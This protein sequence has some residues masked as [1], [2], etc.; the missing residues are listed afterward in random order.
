MQAR[1]VGSL[2][3]RPSSAKRWRSTVSHLAAWLTQGTRTAPR[4]GVSPPHN[5]PGQRTDSAGPGGQREANE[6]FG[7]SEGN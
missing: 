6:G 5:E 7:V 1:Y 2:I 4:R 3:L